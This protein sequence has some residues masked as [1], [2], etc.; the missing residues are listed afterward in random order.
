MVGRLLGEV[1]PIPNKGEWMVASSWGMRCVD[2]L[3]ISLFQEYVETCL[4]T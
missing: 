1:D 2:D 3:D 4:F